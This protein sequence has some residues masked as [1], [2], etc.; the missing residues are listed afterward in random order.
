MGRYQLVATHTLGSAAAEASGITWNWDTDTLFV[1]GDEGKSIVQFSKAGVQIDAMK[2]SGF[3][4]TEGLTYAGA[5]RIIV[6]EERLQDAYEL[7]YAA[8]ATATRS[9]LPVLSIG[10]TVGNEG[11]EGIALDRI[12]GRFIAVKEKSP[13]AVH[14]LNLNFAAGS[15][16]VQ[17]LF[18]PSALALADLSD[19]QPLASVSSLDVAGRM[20]LLILSQESS[21]L[22]EV[23]RAGQIVSSLDISGISTDVEGVTVDQDGTIYLVAQ[24]PRFYVL[25]PR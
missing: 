9:S 1:I 11:I 23:T 4:D 17:S 6:T 7:S 22:L 12:S 15:I 21:R 25:K 2:L 14:E 16:T 10:A 19:V 24:T 13:Q 3:D 5:G 20:N 8:G 18:A